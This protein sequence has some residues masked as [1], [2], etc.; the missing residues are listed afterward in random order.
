M[1]T[2]PS[3]VK[4]ALTD[5]FFKAA[6]GISDMAKEYTLSLDRILQPEIERLLVEAKSQ[7]AASYIKHTYGERCE[8]KDTDDFPEL[9]SD[10]AANRCLTCE[11]WEM[12]DMWL[13]LTHPKQQEENHGQG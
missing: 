4:A 1:T 10:P 11:Q 5:L 6:G 7:G 3:E 9:K 12:Y 8:V 13:K 2:L